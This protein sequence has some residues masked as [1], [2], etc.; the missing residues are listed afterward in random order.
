MAI[1]PSAP[2]KSIAW[3]G[4][5]LDDLREFPA[6][7]QDEFGHELL[8]AQR[9]AR[10]ESARQMKGFKADVTELRQRHD[11]DAYRAVYTVEYAEAVYVLHCFQKKSKTGIKTPQ[12]D[13][14]LIKRRLK[15]AADDWQT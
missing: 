15:Q 13:I 7:V 6:E 4:S 2:R 14:D 9:G 8:L 3:M 5:T 10:G 12:R 1:T 11:G